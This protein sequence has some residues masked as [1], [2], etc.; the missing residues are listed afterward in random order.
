MHRYECWWELSMWP[1]RCLDQAPSQQRWPK[2]L[3]TMSS[4]C[5]NRRDGLPH[6]FP[7]WPWSGGRCHSWQWSHVPD[8]RYGDHFDYQ[9]HGSFTP[10]LTH[11]KFLYASPPLKNN[12]YYAYRPVTP[13]P[14]ALM[15][16]NLPPRDGFLGLS[17][18]AVDFGRLG[19]GH[20]LSTS[21]NSL[22]MTVLWSAAPSAAESKHDLHIWFRQP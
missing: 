16:R 5:I 3:R 13:H 21:S 1:Y 12:W 7:R 8:F 10:T 19:R 11:S 15:M 4:S 22:R 14:P 20:P 6:C 2:Y 17:S 18:Q 9:K